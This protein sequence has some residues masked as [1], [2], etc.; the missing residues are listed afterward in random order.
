[1]DEQ[2]VEYRELS[3]LGATNTTTTIIE[4]QRLHDKRLHYWKMISNYIPWCQSPRNVGLLYLD[5]KSLTISEVLQ[6][7]TMSKERAKHWAQGGPPVSFL[8][9]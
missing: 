9:Q 3:T 5:P 1:M 8:T 2:Y 6:L 4:H 7:S